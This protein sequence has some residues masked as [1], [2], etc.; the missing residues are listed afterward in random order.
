[1]AAAGQAEKELGAELKVIKKTSPEYAAE[2]NPPPCP[3]VKVN[4][5]FIAV[6]DVVTFD[7]LKAAIQS[8]AQPLNFGAG[9]AP[10]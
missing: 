3:S 5:K 6:N 4:E 1:M 7:A 8:A 10:V 2:K 9:S